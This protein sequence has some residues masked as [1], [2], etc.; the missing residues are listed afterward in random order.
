[1]GDYDDTVSH[2]DEGPFDKNGHMKG[3]VM[4]YYCVDVW[5]TLLSTKSW[6]AYF[7]REENGGSQYISPLLF[8][9]V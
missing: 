6:S 5:P 4:S 7:L 9:G 3:E 8:I 1:M 2:F